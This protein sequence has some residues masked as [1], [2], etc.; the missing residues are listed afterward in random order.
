MYVDT[1]SSMEM[2]TTA[3]RLRWTVRLYCLPI[4][5]IYLS[6]SLSDLVRAGSEDLTD[7]GRI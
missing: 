2:S 1:S 5:L 3:E 6:F 4:S 7:N